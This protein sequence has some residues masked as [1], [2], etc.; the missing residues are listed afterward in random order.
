MPYFKKDFFDFLK[1]LSQNNNREW[2]AE[3]KT[4]YELSVKIPFEEFIQD[5]ILRIHEIDDSITVSAKDSIFRI[6]RDVRF[7]KDKK[8]YKEQVSG[9]ICEGGRKNYTVPGTYIEIHHDN[10][11]IYGGAY[12]IDSKLLQNLREYI[13]SNMEEFNSLINDKKFKKVYGELHGE[14]HKR[15]PKE[16]V[17]AA[18]KQPLLFNKQFYFFDRLEP[19]KLLSKNVVDLVMDHYHIARPLSLFLQEGMRG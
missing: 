14:K 9:I 5:V 4:R 2:F 12:F 18:K 11:K 1:E 6:Y 3:N 16:F 7:S 8:P 17:E 10:W 15:L 13:L 19:K